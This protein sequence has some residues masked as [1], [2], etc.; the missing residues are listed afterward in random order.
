VKLWR[1]SHRSQRENGI[2]LLVFHV[3]ELRELKPY[4]FQDVTDK[5]RAE[6]ERTGTPF[7]DLLPV[8]ENLDPASLWVTVPDPHP[9]G[10]AEIA[11][12]KGMMPSIVEALDG[13]CKAEQKGC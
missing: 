5:V 2:K 6:V 4:P 8:I 1:A 13:L 11:L 9:N 12:A 10:K 3:P 7:I